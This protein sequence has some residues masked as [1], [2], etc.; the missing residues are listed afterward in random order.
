MVK[1]IRVW[2]ERGLT[3]VCESGVLWLSDGSGADIILKAGEVY[4]ARPLSRLVI[5]GLQG[6]AT[7]SLATP[8]GPRERGT[9]NAEHTGTKA[10]GNRAPGSG[11]TSRSAERSNSQGPVVAPKSR[12]AG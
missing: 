2:F 10:P 12:K 11:A 8:R 9:L 7:Y 3:L 6:R 5:E 4:A 1:S